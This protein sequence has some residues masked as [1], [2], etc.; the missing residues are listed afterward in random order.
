M[1]IILLINKLY[2][3]PKIKIKNYIHYV[4]N[5][6]LPICRE[7]VKNY[8]GFHIKWFYM[9]LKKIEYFNNNYKYHRN[10]DMPSV[11]EYDENGDIYVIKYFL[12][13]SCHRENKPSIIYFNKGRITYE[14]YYLNGVE[15]VK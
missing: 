14:K 6:S 13:G 2:N 10:D 11:I 8:N 4:F 3:I 5:I 1:I 15:L 9:M 7:Y 12:N